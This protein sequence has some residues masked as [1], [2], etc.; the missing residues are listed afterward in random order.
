M[1]CG[2][3]KSGFSKC[4]PEQPQDFRAVNFGVGE[5]VL[6]LGGAVEVGADDIAVEIADDEQRRIQQGFAVLL[7]LPVGLVE[8]LVPALVFPAETAFFPDIGKTFLGASVPGIVQPQE[9]RVLDHAFL[10]TEEIIA[11][12][13][14]LVGRRL[15]QQ[16]AQ[17]GEMLLVGGS[18]LAP[19][20]RPFLFEFRCGH[21]FN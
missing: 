6:V 12:G 9:F 3:R 19:I 4:R 2:L 20:A 16:A 21:L 8:I 11:A 5:F 18:F 10:E 13:I 7:E 17:V 1:R 14:G 15:A